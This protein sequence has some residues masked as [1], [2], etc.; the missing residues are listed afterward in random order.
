MS[1]LNPIKLPQ[2][3]KEVAILSLAALVS[4]LAVNYMS[5]SGLSLTHPPDFAISKETSPF[6]IVDAAAA[7]R[8]QQKSGCVLVDARSPER[9]KAGHIPGA[10]LLPAYQTDAY[11]FSFFKRYPPETTVI[12]YCTGVDCSDSRVLAEELAA[13]G[14]KNL[15][16]FAGGMDAW[17]E[18]GYAIEKGR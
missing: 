6:P 4:A 9:Y 14:Y 5:P 16:I 10:F 3:L 17:Q 2:L 1:I 7:R 11:I 18:N 8:L 13:A 12:T 15:K